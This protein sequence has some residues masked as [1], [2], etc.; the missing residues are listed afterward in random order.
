MDIFNKIFQE[1]VNYSNDDD[2]DGDKKEYNI[3]FE[4][5]RIADYLEELSLALR[6]K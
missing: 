4:L 2:P 1:A 3:G 5:H 6:F